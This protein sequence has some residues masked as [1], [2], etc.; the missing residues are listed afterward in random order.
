MTSDDETPLRQRRRRFE[1]ATPSSGTWS[2]F[3]SSSPHS[4]ASGEL[5]REIAILERALHD[6]GELGRKEL[7][8]ITG[9]KYWGPARY[10]AAL[11]AA[12]DQKRIRKTG[13]ARYS[14]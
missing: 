4:R 14:L 12:L 6:K 7:G 5:E 11:R 8:E 3:L 9:S 10:S 1:P 13:R 2:P